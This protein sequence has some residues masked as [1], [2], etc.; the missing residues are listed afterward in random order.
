MNYHVQWLHW[1]T[2]YHGNLEALK[3]E[4]EHLTTTH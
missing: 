2:G 3:G 4:A 1:V